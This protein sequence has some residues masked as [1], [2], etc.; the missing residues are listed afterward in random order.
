MK[1]LTDKLAVYTQVFYTKAPKFERVFMERKRKKL[2]E[3]ML[4][5]QE[6]L[7]NQINME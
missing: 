1:S 5:E 6:E 4:K 7:E 2:E 3:M